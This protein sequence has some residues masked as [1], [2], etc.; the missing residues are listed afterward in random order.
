MKMKLKRTYPLFLS[1]VFIIILFFVG[2]N[3]WAENIDPLNSNSQYAYGENV[4][5]FNGEPNVGSGV[6]VKNL[7]LTGYIWVENIGWINLHPSN[8]GGVIN[9][10]HGC[11]SG[12]AWG[13][14]VGWINFAPTHGGVSID[15]DSGVFSGYA[16]GE[17]IGWISFASTHHSMATSWHKF[18]WILF[19][20]TFVTKKN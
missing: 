8:Y 20:P 5:W 9:D 3:A 6:E 16:W 7:M 19:Y 2:G 11:L 17:N 10:G 18:P 1:S 13:E 12:Y 15:T 4:G 14:N